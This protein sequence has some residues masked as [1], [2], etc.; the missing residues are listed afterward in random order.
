MFL[1][2]DTINFTFK[3]C[4]HDKIFQAHETVSHCPQY[5]NVTS[6]PANSYSSVHPSA[7]NTFSH[8]TDVL[9][10][11]CTNL[12]SSQLQQQWSQNIHVPVTGM[13]GSDGEYQFFVNQA[14]R[15]FNMIPNDGVDAAT[16]SGRTS[17]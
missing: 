16:E 7:I 17:A 3:R 14:E 6:T 9:S 2:L 11:Q 10:P 13:A 5:I 1:R 12:R 8:T 15:L 4:L